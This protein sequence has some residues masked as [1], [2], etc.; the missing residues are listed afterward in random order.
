MHKEDFENNINSMHWLYNTLFIIR[1]ISM[2]RS[3]L[4]NVKPN[5]IFNDSDL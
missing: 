4:G 1:L 3:N 2:I 5:N